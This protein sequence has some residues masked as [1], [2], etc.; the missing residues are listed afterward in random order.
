MFKKI[1]VIL[2]S[3]SIFSLIACE[4]PGPRY[5]NVG[6]FSEG[7]APV[8]NAN[9]KWGYINEKQYWVIPSRFD[10]AK[11]FKDGKAAVKQNGKW[12]FINKQGKWL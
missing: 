3:L 7:L 8:Q 5:R 12:G 11:E 6:Q 4:S 2:L 1:T 10:E 9:G